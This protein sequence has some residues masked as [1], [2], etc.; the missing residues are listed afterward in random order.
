MTPKPKD[1]PA[2]KVKQRNPPMATYRMVVR[3]S[4]EKSEKAANAPSSSS[5]SIKEQL[6]WENGFCAGAL[7]MWRRLKK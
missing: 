3:V 5:L 7:W 6:R 1:K 2:G 4:Q